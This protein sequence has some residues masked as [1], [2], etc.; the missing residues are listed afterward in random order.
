VT[1]SGRLGRPLNRR[2]GN[3]KRYRWSTR[4]AK[5]RLKTRLLA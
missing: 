3:K 5:P 1:E 2:H 4:L